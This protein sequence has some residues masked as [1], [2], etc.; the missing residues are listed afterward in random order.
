VRINRLKWSLIAVLLI[1]LLSYIFINLDLN[2]Y[3][4]Q[5]EERTGS[6]AAQAA[7]VKPVTSLPADDAFQPVAETS[8]LQLKADYASGHFVVVDKR[9]GDLWRSYPNPQQWNPDEESEQWKTTLLSPF[10]F[11]YIDRSQDKIQTKDTSMVKEAGYVSRSEK[12]SDGVEFTF[13]L[14]EMNV[15]VTVQVRIKDD[16]VETTIVDE[17]LLES[18]IQLVHLRLYPFFGA[19]KSAEQ[20]GY[21]LIPDGSGALI[22]FKQHANNT[23]YVYE[24]DVYGEDPVF[25][26]F[27]PKSNRKPVSMP[28]YGIKTGDKAVLAVLKDGAEYAKIVAK[29][30]SAEEY[31]WATGQMNY[32]L[33]YFQPTSSDK[34][35]GF[36]TYSK[37]RYKDDRSIRYYLLGSGE[38][39]YTGMAARYRQ[40]LMDEYGLSP[41]SK[42]KFL[43]LQLHLLGGDIEKGFMR[44]SYL[45][46]TTT[47]EAMEI[48]K[49]LYQLGVD[50]MAVTYFGW[51]TGGYSA[52]GGNFPVDPRIGGNNGMKTF[53][54]F[55]RSL[56]FPVFLDGSSYGTSGK[57]ADG[58]NRKRDGL[59][60][61]AG[62]IMESYVYSSDTA[63]SLISPQVTRQRVAGDLEK[64]AWL[65]AD[66]IAF[67]GM[68]GSTL[69]SDFN[70]KYMTTRQETRLI[71]EE[72]LREAGQSFGSLR[73]SAGN[74]YTVPYVKHMDNLFDDY[75][76]DAGVDEAVPFAQISLHGLIT[77]TSGYSNQRD[78]YK[79]DFL[80]SIEYGALPSY[81][82]TGTKSQEL[83]QTYGVSNFFSTY[84]EDWMPSIVSEYQTYNKALADVQHEFITGHRKL[85]EGVFE[86]HYANGK[87]IVVNYNKHAVTVEGTAI[88]GEDFAIRSGGEGGAGR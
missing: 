88:P 59:R 69:S 8:T 74:F 50:R 58:F 32:R 46:E 36:F 28:V 40:M 86:T 18:H 3:A 10:S 78:N 60:D 38:A 15:S 30:G 71:Q 76:Y 13:A 21:F 82:I 67:G 43:P 81:V 9:S 77:Y 66:G 84:Y 45:T 41:L 37:D 39:D 24:E 5:R 12:L 47:S 65:G 85:A 51:Q 48:V 11:R 44:D 72:L 63:V 6:G 70:S 61:L 57:G 49:Q 29:P 83:L 1:G 42:E 62:G 19:E 23:D 14:P 34:K 33:S 53:I 17:K 54:G 27:S 64:F 80:R 55:A 22:R 20:E 26:H 75:S 2:E 16:Y 4:S 35:R 73:M 25:K 87:R 56:G 79:K 68:T 7:T 31:N 52:S